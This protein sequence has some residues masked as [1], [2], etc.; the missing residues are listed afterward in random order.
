M[1]QYH[2]L[3]N[4]DK[5]EVVSPHSIGLG[6]KQVEHTHVVA[7]LADVLY[8]LT[9]TS[10]NRGGGDLAYSDQYEERFKTFG[11]WVGDR[12]AVLGDYTETEDVPFLR[13]ENNEGLHKHIESF[14]E[15]SDSILPAFCHAFGV[16]IE[17]GVGWRDR[18][19]K[20]EDWHWLFPDLKSDMS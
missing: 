13:F 15:I 10:P 17:K 16:T 3:V 14:T 4:F 7:S 19:L 11:R 2:Q 20:A 9:T 12:V 6:F 5:K 18:E 8:I 1:G